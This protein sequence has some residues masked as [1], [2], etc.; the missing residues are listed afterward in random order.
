MSDSGNKFS[1]ISEFSDISDDKLLTCTQLSEQLVRR[2][3][4]AVSGWSGR[5]NALFASGRK[6]VS[7]AFVYKWG[8]ATDG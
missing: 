6:G 3:L 5:F 8:A 7:V 2:F 1:E 4:T